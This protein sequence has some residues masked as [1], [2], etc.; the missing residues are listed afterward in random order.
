MTK[1]PTTGFDVRYLIRGLKHLDR[2]ALEVLVLTLIKYWIKVID[3]VFSI[4]FEW[5]IEGGPVSSAMKSE[6]SYKASAQVSR[7]SSQ[8]KGDVAKLHWQVVDVWARAA[9][10][11]FSLITL[12]NFIYSHNHYTDPKV[13]LVQDNITLMGCSKTHVW[14]AVTDPKR[15]VTNMT[16]SP[17]LCVG[18]FEQA[19]QLIIMPISSLIRCVLVI[20]QI[21]PLT[22]VHWPR[23]KTWQGVGWPLRECDSGLPVFYWSMWLNTFG[24][25][26]QQV[27]QW[28]ILTLLDSMSLLFDRVR[29]CQAIS[30]CLALT[31]AHRYYI[32]GGLSM[33]KY[34]DLL[35]ALHRVLLKPKV[36]APQPEVV[37]IKYQHFDISFQ[38]MLKSMF[39][40][41]K[42]LFLCRAIEPCVSSYATAYQRMASFNFHSNKFVAYTLANFPLLYNHGDWRDF[43]NKMLR[44]AGPDNI[45]IWV[46]ARFV[47]VIEV[48]LSHRKVF[49]HVLLFEDLVKD[50]RK[51][52]KEIFD[53]VNVDHQNL[54]PALAAMDTDSQQGLLGVRWVSNTWPS[55]IKLPHSHTQRSEKVDIVTDDEARYGRLFGGIAIFSSTSRLDCW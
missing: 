47:A 7:K 49:D 22:I 52:L 53:V 2:Q 55:P 44:V 29:S 14:F 25:N 42:F 24:T 34:K 51:A 39:P 37:F 48:A 17:F 4:V 12:D 38:G 10:A 43:M 20:T 31:F 28:I 35:Q 9:Y 40:R 54:E 26:V 27:W 21:E 50:P 11:K 41:F 33:R 3:F 36:N 1:D 6:E 16:H 46:A 5:T 8:D 15:D 13:V 32:L 23:F 18:Q 45:H 30:I 19:K